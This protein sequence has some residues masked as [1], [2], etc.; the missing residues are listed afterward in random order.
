MSGAALPTQRVTPVVVERHEGGVAET[1]ERQLVPVRPDQEIDPGRGAVGHRG[2]RVVG[3]QDAVDD[4]EERKRDHPRVRAPLA[5][6]L[7]GGHELGRRHPFERRP[8]ARRDPQD[9]RQSVAPLAP[10]RPPSARA[11]RRSARWRGGRALGGRRAEQRGHAES[12]GGLAEDGDGARITTKGRDV[13]PHPAQGSHLVVDAP[14]SDQ[15]V[16]IGQ[17]PVT[18]EAQGAEPVVDGDDHGVAVAH[19]V[20]AP[21]EEDRAAART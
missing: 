3:Q 1:E 15:P 14:V 19:Q 8:G 6:L 16:G 12:S 21:V 7:G 11:P 4:R 10:P 17:V 20:A 2:Q 9:G 5:D 13:V 18:E